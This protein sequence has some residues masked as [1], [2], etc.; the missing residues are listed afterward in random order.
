MESNFRPPVFRGPSA[1]WVRTAGPP[2]RPS[3]PSLKETLENL[4]DPSKGQGA[5]RL[6]QQ[7]AGDKAAWDVEWAALTCRLEQVRPG[8]LS[9]RGEGLDPRAWLGKGGEEKP[10]ATASGTWE[11][12]RLPVVPSF[13]LLPSPKVQSTC[14]ELSAQGL[15]P[16]RWGCALPS[17]NTP[18]KAPNH[19]HTTLRWHFQPPRHWEN[20]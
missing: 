4:L 11:V 19:I 16:L 12:P 20:I 2:L 10:A 8:L 15:V 17:P 14:P 7:Y 3:P 6:Q 18:G 5:R 9:N 13:P 1:V